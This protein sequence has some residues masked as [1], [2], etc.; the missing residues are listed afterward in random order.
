MKRENTHG[1]YINVESGELR[2]DELTSNSRCKTCNN[3]GIKGRN[4]KRHG[5]SV[6]SC[7]ETTVEVRICSLLLRVVLKGDFSRR[8]QLNCEENMTRR[9]QLESRMMKAKSLAHSLDIIPSLSS[10]IIQ[11]QPL[12]SSSCLAISG[13]Q[14][15]SQ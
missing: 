13:S 6:S 14:V 12:L 7:V 9:T 10:S 15:A 8:E 1:K 5:V 2:E 4:N 3:E 11:L